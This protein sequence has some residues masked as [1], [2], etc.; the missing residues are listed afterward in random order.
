MK[1]ILLQN[2]ANLGKAGEI[3]EV[4]DGF[5]RNFLF[6]KKLAEPATNEAL[7]KVARINEEAK[8]KEAE[9]VDDL[10]NRSRELEGKKIV[11]KVKEKKGKLFGSVTAKDITK[12]FLKQ[13]IKVDEASINLGEPIKKIGEK[14]IK[15][16]FGHGINAKIILLIEGE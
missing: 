5:A 8:K 4:A 12:E 14:E 6:P 11:I 15:I 7:Q 10:K 9:A 13:G 16:S 3:K 1:I 2:L